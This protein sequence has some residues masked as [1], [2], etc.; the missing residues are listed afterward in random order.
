MPS[1]V[2]KFP[3]LTYGLGFLAAF[4]TG[5]NSYRK[6]CFQKLMSLE[7]SFIADKFREVYAVWVSD[8]V[9]VQSSF[10]FNRSEKIKEEKEKNACGKFHT[11]APKP[12]SKPVVK[13]EKEEPPINVHTYNKDK[14][15]LDTSVEGQEQ[16]SAFSRNTGNSQPTYSD[17]SQDTAVKK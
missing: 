4:M 12:P 7:N 2:T 3:G 1:F 17:P 13:R 9:A 6:T 15:M 8:L 14:A 16:P 11:Q 5:A 10:S